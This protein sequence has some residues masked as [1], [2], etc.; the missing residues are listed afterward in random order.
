MDLARGRAR[1]PLCDSTLAA[2]LVPPSILGFAFRTASLIKPGKLLITI[3]RDTAL[4]Y[5]S[6]KKDSATTSYTRF[7]VR[8]TAM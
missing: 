6:A 3:W 8:N 1:L 5:S 2:I 4:F 7:F